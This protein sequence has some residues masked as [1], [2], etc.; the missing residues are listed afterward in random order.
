MPPK[1]LTVSNQRRSLVQSSDWN[2]AINRVRD[3]LQ[4]QINTLNNKSNLINVSN[5]ALYF[6]STD[7]VSTTLSGTDNGAKNMFNAEVIPSYDVD[8]SNVW[9]TS[10][11][12]SNPFY[13]VLEYKG[14]VNISAVVDVTYT[15]TTPTDGQGDATKGWNITANLYLSQGGGDYIPVNSQYD[16]DKYKFKSGL[17]IRISCYPLDRT[18]TGHATYK[19]S[20]TYGDRLM[21]KLNTDNTSDT[22]SCTVYQAKINI[23]NMTNV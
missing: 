15:V 6:N 18:H 23:M 10:P 1:S 16:T 13:G 11:R 12:V 21:V 5:T 19:L 4:S 2:S 14:L 7:G 17:P 3:E 8:D 22:A 20:L 9:F